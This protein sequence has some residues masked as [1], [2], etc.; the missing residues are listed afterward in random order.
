MDSVFGWL[1]MTGLLIGG[2][3]WFVRYAIA[4]YERYLYNRNHG[5]Q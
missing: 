4:E 1:F 5:W 2:A 3:V